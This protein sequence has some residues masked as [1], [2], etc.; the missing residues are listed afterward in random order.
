[1]LRQ[2]FINRLSYA[3]SALPQYERDKVIAYYLELIADR[4]EGGESEE[5]IIAG[6]GDIN[7]LAQSILMENNIYPEQMQTKKSSMAPLVIVLLIVFSPVIFGL[8]MAA[9]GITIGFTCA[10]FSVVFALFVASFALALSGVLCFFT[11]FI[12]LPTT[13]AYAFLQ[14]GA[15]L[16]L[17]G[18]SIFLFMGTY[19]LSKGVIKLFGIIFSGI[20]NIFRK[21]RTA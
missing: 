1:M 17:A 19:Y 14:M 20:K 12:L 11:S 15:G 8:F 16:L 5:D 13:P 2:E 7:T 18:I 10:I 21:R 6:F 9:F 3:I 4:I